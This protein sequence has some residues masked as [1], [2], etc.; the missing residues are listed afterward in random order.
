MG[1]RT[2]VFQTLSIYSCER[3]MCLCVRMFMVTHT[4]STHDMHVHVY[5][6]LRYALVFWCRLILCDY[7]Y[8]YY[9]DPFVWDS[10]EF[11]ERHFPFAYFQI[12]LGS[13]CHYENAERAAH[14]NDVDVV[15]EQCLFVLIC[16]YPC[17]GVCMRASE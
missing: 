17:M 12:V 6:L 1:D 4:H 11:W 2:C 3:C 13:C 14:L 7:Y 15:W 16:V 5:C 8:Y 9:L 10:S